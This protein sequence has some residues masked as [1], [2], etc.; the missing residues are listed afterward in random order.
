M[1]KVGYFIIALSLTLFISCN[2]SK[3]EKAK[4]KVEMETTMGVSKPSDDHFQ[5]VISALKNN[6]DKE[7]AINL[8]EG[9]AQLNKEAKD[10][11]GVHKVNLEKATSHLEMLATNLENGK[12]VD[13]N[14]VRELIAN[15]EINVSHNYLAE[16]DSYILEDPRSIEANATHKR[17]N[18]VLSNLD[19]IEGNVKADSKK[20]HE[21][22]VSEGKKLKDEYEDWE[23][24]T[25]EFNKKANEH[26]KK[27]YP[28]YYSEEIGVYPNN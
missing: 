3:N 2:E 1:K 15:A 19:K 16:D 25:L 13:I 28:E 26:F 8:R 17:F 12:K 4:E 20:D 21:A 22:L 5:Q 7:A 10:K 18:T 24:R 27:H 14:K 11:I 6:Q 23:K 9:I